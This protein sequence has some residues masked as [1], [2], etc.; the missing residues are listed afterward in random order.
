MRLTMTPPDTPARPP[1]V[2]LF[3]PITW[4]DEWSYEEEA[5]VLDPLGVE[6]VIPE[7]RAARD[8]LMPEADVVVVSS[9]DQLT[10][11]HIERLE[12]CVGILCYSAGMDA[13]DLEAAR[14]AEIPVANVQSGTD[15]VADH[16]MTLLLAAWR[17]LPEMTTEAAAGHWHLEQNPQF[18]NIRRLNGKTLGILGAG[19]IG[20]AVAVRARGFGMRTIGTYRR[21][22]TAEPELPPVPLE[23]LMAE[24][25]ALVLTASLNSSTKGIINAHALSMAKPGLIL[26]NVARGGLIVES[27][28]ADALDSGTVA[29]AALDVRETEPPEPTN[30]VLGG[31]SDVIQTPHMAGVTSEALASLHRL[32]ADQMERLLRE[33]GRL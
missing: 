18:K 3:D 16:A 11:S 2:L 32:A 33:G 24:S 8:E 13:V 23:Q 22:E 5:S 31:R 29:I 14:S 20:R 12:R 21:P 25:D 28:L 15:D 27:D 17:R 9:V 6:L 1:R 26:V 19:A 7:D 4:V 10:A 30:D